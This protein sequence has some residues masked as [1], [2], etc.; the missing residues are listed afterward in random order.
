[1]LSLYLIFIN[2]T[3]Q[4][5]TQIV[6]SSVFLIFYSEPFI[7][8]HKMLMLYVSN[9]NELVTSSPILSVLSVF[10]LLTV[11]AIQV[12]IHLVEILYLSDT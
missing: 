1:M 10:L 3:V 5:F 7:C 6:N 8:S 11:L 4:T 12:G 2:G 9:Y